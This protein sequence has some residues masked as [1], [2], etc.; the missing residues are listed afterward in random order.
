MF[1]ETIIKFCVFRKGDFFMLMT[2]AVVIA[3]VMA[4][5]L[6]LGLYIAKKVES[7]EDW[8]VAG[9]QLGIV[10]S[11]GTYFA[12]L[13]S[14]V[15]VIGYTGYYYRLGWGGWFN[16][17]GTIVSCILFSMWYAGR[18]RRYGKVTLPDFVEER[19]GKV[20]SG[21]SSI[22]VVLSCTIL[23]C[24]QLIGMGALMKTIFGIPSIYSII[25]IGILFTIFTV[26]GGMLSVAYTDTMCSGIMLVGLYIMMFIL[27]G[28]VDGFE[29][30][31]RVIAAQKPSMLSPFAGGAMHWG[32]IFSWAIV[33]GIGNLGSPQY[34][35]R[36]YAAKDEKTARMSQGLC[37]LLFFVA[38]LPLMIIGLAAFVLI[39]GITAD[40][41]VVPTVLFKLV[42]PA[43]GGL[44]A[45]AL[46]CASIST[47]DSVLLMA[48]TTAIRDIQQ[49]F[50]NP[51]LS[52]EKVLRNSRLATLGIGAASIVI[53]LFLSGSVMW[54]HINMQNIVAST[55]ALPVI[56][57][58]AVRWINNAGTLA[59]MIGGGVTAVAWLMAGQPMGLMPVIPGLAVCAVLMLGV[60]YITKRPD[61]V[62][63]EKFFGEA[64][65]E[66]EDNAILKKLLAQK[67]PTSGI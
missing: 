3:L 55:L 39:P 30:L 34:M 16:W 22:I 11:T 48:G 52:P 45:S 13:I 26:M 25:V 37:G 38:Y 23:C 64:Q 56:L 59:G 14:S 21:I 17:T 66:E 60:S 20:A 31:H 15:S 24:S 27:L 49:K 57:G 58:F 2:Y 33:N 6:F 54:I 63:V 1:T 7:A 32:M 8:Q 46:L 40:N 12:T 41:D 62:I 28:K 43:V 53:S 19:F 18:I 67:T 35:T 50:F 9:R 4:V 61:P 10:L 42:P 5:L 29:N 36:F 47:A 65:F 44:V 51:G